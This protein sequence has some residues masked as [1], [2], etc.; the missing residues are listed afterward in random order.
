[1]T[2]IL[3][4]VNNRKKNSEAIQKEKKKKEKRLNRY[5]LMIILIEFN[6]NNEF[7]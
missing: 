7:K 1:M 2:K 4:G 6:L 5:K 3:T